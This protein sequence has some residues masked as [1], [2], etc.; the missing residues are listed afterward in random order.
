M[1]RSTG[2]DR[3]LGPNDVLTISLNSPTAEMFLRTASSRPDIC[4]KKI[5]FGISISRDRYT[6]HD[7][8]MKI[9]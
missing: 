6:G 2:R 9:C 7:E 3:P 8:T 5:H 1:D 4:C